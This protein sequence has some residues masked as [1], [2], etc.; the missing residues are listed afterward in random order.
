[1]DGLRGRTRGVPASKASGRRPDDGWDDEA[2]VL[3]GPEEE[4]VTLGGDLGEEVCSTRGD[5][6]F[7][8]RGIFIE[9]FAGDGRLFDHR[10]IAG[11]PVKLRPAPT[12]AHFP[13]REVD[14]APR[15]R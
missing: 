7:G 13:A 6:R 11:A 3:E 5:V 8:F 10:I 2:S 4:E 14:H 1:L 9:A 12:W 15:R